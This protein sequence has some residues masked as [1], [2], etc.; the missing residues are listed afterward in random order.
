MSHAHFKAVLFDCKLLTGGAA[1]LSRFAAGQLEEARPLL[2]TAADML[3][4]QLGVRCWLHALNMPLTGTRC[5]IHPTKT[6]VQQI[7]VQGGGS[8]LVHKSAAMQ[9]VCEPSHCAH[10]HCTNPHGL[11]QT[12][13]S[14]MILH[15][16]PPASLH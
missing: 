9:P 7:R 11:H 3:A 8:W 10:Q 16:A 13:P 4:A 14:P 5:G 12:P 1:V 2:T 6:V 15:H